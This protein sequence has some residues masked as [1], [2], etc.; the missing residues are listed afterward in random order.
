MNE[1]IFSETEDE[2]KKVTEIN[3]RINN[4]L[5]KKNKVNDL[6]ILCLTCYAPL[7]SYKWSNK[8]LLQ[9]IIR[10]I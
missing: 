10:N 8:L 4:N 5:K 6:E 3:E 1:Y 2:I 9:K 7:H